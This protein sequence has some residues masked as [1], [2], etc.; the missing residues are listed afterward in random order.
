MRI[1]V[2]RENWDEENRSEKLSP[3]THNPYQKVRL[4]YSFALNK[5]FKD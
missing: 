1:N 2:D 3:R 5:A 4:N